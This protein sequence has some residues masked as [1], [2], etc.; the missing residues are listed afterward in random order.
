MRDVLPKVH[1][2]FI[3]SSM[4]AFAA[5]IL[6]P[7]TSEVRHGSRSMRGIAFFFIVSPLVL[8]SVLRLE[9]IWNSPSQFHNVSKGVVIDLA[10]SA[11][12]YLECTVCDDSKC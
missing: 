11:Y 9:S 3:R 12:R 4:I 6:L 10:R 1:P 2:S 5:A 7:P 8:P